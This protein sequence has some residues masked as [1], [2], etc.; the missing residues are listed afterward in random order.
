MDMIFKTNGFVHTDQPAH[1]V[2]ETSFQLDID[3]FIPGV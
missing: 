1:F 3:L 2:S